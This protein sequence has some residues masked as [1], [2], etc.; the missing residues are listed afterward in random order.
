MVLIKVIKIVLF[1]MCFAPMSFGA[2]G[3]GILF[4]QFLVSASRN[5]AEYEKLYGTCLT[6]FAL[7]ETFSF[8]SLVVAFLISL[9]Y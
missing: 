8:L 4:G 7:I 5:P 3:T 2:L 1:G 6:A 9:S